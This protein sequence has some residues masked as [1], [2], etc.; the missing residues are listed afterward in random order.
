MA[1]TAQVLNAEERALLLKIA[2]CPLIAEALRGGRPCSQ[3]VGA[4]RVAADADR[5]VPEAWAGN[6]GDA[7]VLF[8]SSNPSISEPGP[9][10]PAD[11]VEPFPTASSTDHNIVEFIGR[12]FDQSV[13][14]TPWVRDGR[15][16]LRNGH[17]SPTPTRFWVS[18]RARAQELLGETADP[19]CDYVMTEVVH[20]KSRQ[21]IGVAAAAS[22]CATL[23]LTEILRLSAA[24]LI[25][26][27]GKK[28]HNALAAWLPSLPAPPYV[29]DVELGGQPRTL[30][31]ISHPSSWGEPKTIAAIYG[32]E[33]V[34]LLRAIA[35]GYSTEFRPATDSPDTIPVPQTSAV[36][37]DRL[38]TTDRIRSGQEHRSASSR[39]PG[40]SRPIKP[41]PGRNLSI[42]E[43]SGTAIVATRE[44]VSAKPDPAIRIFTGNTAGR[45]VGDTFD[46]YH[47][48]NGMPCGVWTIIATIEAGR[49][50]G[51]HLPEGIRAFRVNNLG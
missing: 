22:T 36:H 28:A 12:R 45:Q 2:R 43:I 47:K 37:K 24:P 42:D 46:S 5:Q 17:Y 9:S 27:V 51:G 40:P 31:Y 50:T 26:V 20:C 14:P 3:I 15:S 1:R 44:T 4:Q 35:R 25:A 41:V 13:L 11:A 6:L 34:E 39:E 16:L 10:Q 23:Y 7:R 8:L 19:A 38:G 33:K 18:I 48:V 32:P 49:L 29:I 21:E 30:V